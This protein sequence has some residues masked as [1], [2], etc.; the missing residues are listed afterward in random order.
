MNARPTWGSLEPVQASPF[1][2]YEHRSAAVKARWDPR[3]VPLPAAF[4]APSMVSTT[5]VAAIRK[6]FTL[7][8]SGKEAWSTGQREGR[9][10]VR[11]A[12][13]VSR[14]HQ[15]VFKRKIGQSTTR[16]RVS[17]LIDASGSMSYGNSAR[18]PHPT[19][20][21]RHLRVNP[22]MAAA[23]FGSTI[24]MALGNVP[25]VMLNIYQHS[26]GGGRMHL[27]WRW[28]KGTPYAAFNENLQGIGGGGNADGHAVYAIATKMVKDLK[29]HE[30]G[31]IMVVS[32]GLPSVYSDDGTSTNGQALIDAVNYCREQGIEVIAV[33]IDGS[34]QSAY[35][36]K[37]GMLPFSG[38]WNA[39]GTDLARHIGRALAPR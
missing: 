5:A 31:V 18:L 16:V 33:A 29:R 39:L 22:N 19:E 37:E 2:E 11:Q 35:Y 25:T 34:D 7:A 14:G 4:D 17:V 1:T 15:D 13:R 10:D 9:F 30:R 36:G 24:A 32:D 28:T 27:K 21:R 26:A 38:D 6:A 23:V 3:V 12:M 8:K 20:P